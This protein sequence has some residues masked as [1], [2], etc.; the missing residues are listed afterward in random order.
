MGETYADGWRDAMKE[1]DKTLSS[2]LKRNGTNNLTS[3]LSDVA[4]KLHLMNN[5]FFSYAQTEETGT[6][7]I[8]ETDLIALRRIFGAGTFIQINEGGISL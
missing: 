2:S 8:D 1:V 6:I 3:V 7:R 4:V 5:R